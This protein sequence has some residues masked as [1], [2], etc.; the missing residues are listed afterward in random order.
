M[1]LSHFSKKCSQTFRDC[2]VATDGNDG[3]GEP[4]LAGSF[5]HAWMRHENRHCQSQAPVLGA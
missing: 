5:G 2:V 3:L 1:D 4:H